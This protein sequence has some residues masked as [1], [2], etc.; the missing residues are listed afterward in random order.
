MCSGNA[1]MKKTRK[2]TRRY[3]TI[4]NRVLLRTSK[5]LLAVLLLSCLATSWSSEKQR[6]GQ[7]W[8]PAVGINDRFDESVLYVTDRAPSTADPSALTYGS[9]RSRTM[10]FGSVALTSRQP[11]VQA[12]GDGRGIVPL[13]VSAITK[14]GEFPPSPY[15]IELTKEGPRRYQAAVDAHLSAAASL[16]REIGVRLKAVRRKEIVVFVHGYNNSFEDAAITAGRFCGILSNEFVCMLLSWPAGG[17]GGAVFGYNIDRESG[18]FA[19][20]DLKKAIR[21]ISATPQVENVHLI[22]HSRGADVLL[23]TLQ[24][25]GMEAYSTRSS[26]AER[27]KINNVVL[28]APDVDLDIAATK[29]FGFVSDPDA[30]YGALATP[31][32]V[33]PQVGSLHLTIYSSPN[34]MVLALSRGLFGSVARL[35]RLT[36]DDISAEEAGANPLWRNLHL[37]R[38]ADFIEYEGKDGFGGHSYFL[39]DPAIERDIIA[40]LRDRRKVGD[41]ARPLVAIK[42]PFWKIASEPSLGQ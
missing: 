3:S 23:S 11:V 9:V 28:F 15:L 42:P 38:V 14:I 31:Y 37:T 18:E 17:N 6:E 33:L 19:V 12:G 20:A 13:T 10:S 16:Q 4:E 25:L 2:I 7:E 22:A 8:S 29:L 32:G 41:P 40:L 1:N 27:Y 5:L 34:D 26:P 30:P 36:S 35:G 39:S 21:I 24:H